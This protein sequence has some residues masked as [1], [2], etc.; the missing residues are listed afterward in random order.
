MNCDLGTSARTHMHTRTSYTHTHTQNN[1]IPKTWP[2]PLVIT[3][4]FFFHYLFVLFLCVFVCICLCLCPSF[5]LSLSLSLSLAF[6]LPPQVGDLLSIFLSLSPLASSIVL[7]QV[8]VRGAGGRGWELYGG[9]G[10]GGREKGRGIEREEES[11]ND[12]VFVHIRGIDI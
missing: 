1:Y 6:S 5:S 10:M 2:Y 9:L 12:S 3:F 7:H 4:L 8:C 11:E